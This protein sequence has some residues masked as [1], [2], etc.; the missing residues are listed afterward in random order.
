MVWLTVCCACIINNWHVQFW[1]ESAK[2]LAI[3]YLFSYNKLDDPI[4]AAL[5]VAG[6]ITK[7]KDQILY[8]SC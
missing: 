2:Q 8:E 4:I 6:H 1:G 5:F 7:R 3:V